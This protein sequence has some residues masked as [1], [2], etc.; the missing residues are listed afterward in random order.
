MKLMM[1]V[2]DII[3]NPK[4]KVAEL[5]PELS[6]FRTNLCIATD[7]QPLIGIVQFFRVVSPWHDRSDEIGK[8]ILELQAVDYG[9]HSEL[10]EKLSTFRE[11]LRNA[12]RDKYG[13]N[14]TKQGEAINDENVFLG[15][16]WGLWTRN[17]WHWKAEKNAPKGGWGFPNMEHLNAYDVVSKQAADFMRSHTG[18]ICNIIEWLETNAKQAKVA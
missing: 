8:I 2:K 7:N 3:G 9:Q 11:H 6:Q 4:K 5:L 10:I 14:R 1:R 12:G 13:M 18:P 17:V 15:N 16:V